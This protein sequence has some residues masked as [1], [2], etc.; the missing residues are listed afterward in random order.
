ME[1]PREGVG[2]QNKPGQDAPRQDKTVDSHGLMDQTDAFRVRLH[3]AQKDVAT[4]AL[5]PLEV[6]CVV[7]VVCARRKEP[8]PDPELEMELAPEVK[9]EARPELEPK[10]EP[11]QQSEL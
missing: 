8:E 7:C 10:L 4:E 2:A 9:H 1:P 5:G 3:L 6:V 11:K